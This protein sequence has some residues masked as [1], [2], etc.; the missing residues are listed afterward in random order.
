MMQVVAPIWFAAKQAAPSIDVSVSTRSSATCASSVV[1]G[2]HTCERMASSFTSS[3]I[4]MLRSRMVRHSMLVRGFYH[5][6][7]DGLPLPSFLRLSSPAMCYTL[8]AAAWPSLGA[9]VRMWPVAVFAPVC[10]PEA[11]AFA[12][13]ATSGATSLAFATALRM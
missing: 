11:T 1:A 5:E 13:W 8:P 6:G 3:L 4:M 12:A 7:G 2:V 10:A 9:V